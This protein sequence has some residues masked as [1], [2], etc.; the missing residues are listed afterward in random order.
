MKTKSRSRFL[1]MLSALYGVSV[2]AATELAIH[3]RTAPHSAAGSDH[4][5]QLTEDLSHLDTVKAAAHQTLP[6][7]DAA[8]IIDKIMTSKD[9]DNSYLEDRLLVKRKLCSAIRANNSV[10]KQQFIAAISAFRAPD[11]Q[12]VP[13][14]SATAEYYS[15]DGQG[16]GEVIITLSAP[17]FFF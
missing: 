12:E 9:P 16:D 1:V 17:L 2:Q 11:E 4:G 8:S 6:R 10:V 5:Q 7:Y 3:P 15:D 13:F 14:W